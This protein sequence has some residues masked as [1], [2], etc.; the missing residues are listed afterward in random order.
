MAIIKH[1]PLL[2]LVL[3]FSTNADV[4][5]CKQASGKIIYQSTPCPTASSTQDIVKIEEMD[6][7]KAEEAKARLKAW[8][9]Q[10]AIKDAEEIEA[11]KQRQIELDRQESLELQ[12]R[13]AIAQEQQAITAQQQKQDGPAF[14]VAPRFNQHYWVNKPDSPHSSNHN[15][16]LKQR[17]FSPMLTPPS[18]L[19]Y[20]ATQP[21][22]RHHGQ[23]S[24]RSSLH[25]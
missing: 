13:S 14:Y 7:Q 4:F 2:L 21:P 9:E 3:S 10:Q 19:P 1:T 5:K 20:P 6:P 12:R 16:L 17:M 8:Q 22:A 15:D 23:S 24:N 25:P 11:K 18:L